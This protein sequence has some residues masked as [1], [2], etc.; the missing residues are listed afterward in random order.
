MS[1]SK[2][3]IKAGIGR[4]P[5][6]MVTQEPVYDRKIKVHRPRKKSGGASQAKYL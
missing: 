1:C 6:K 2:A 5:Q 4:T 3:N